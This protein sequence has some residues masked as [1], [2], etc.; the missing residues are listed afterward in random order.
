MILVVMAWVLTVL[1]VTECWF[2]RLRRNNDYDSWWWT[3]IGLTRLTMAFAIIPVI[4][5]FRGDL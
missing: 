3:V 1:F 5:Y 4:A 2:D